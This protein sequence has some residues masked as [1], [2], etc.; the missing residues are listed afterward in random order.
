MFAVRVDIF[1]G[2][3]RTSSRELW[4][5]C[6]G[7]DAGP[8]QDCSGFSFQRR[9]TVGTRKCGTQERF[10]GYA[11]SFCRAAVE[12]SEVEVWWSATEPKKIGWTGMRIHDAGIHILIHA[13][14]SAKGAW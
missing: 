13:F 1:S 5:S 4:S 12:V 6:L 2:I 9:R 3:G 7:R 10:C 8:E 11:F 14:G